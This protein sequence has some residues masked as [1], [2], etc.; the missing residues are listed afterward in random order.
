MC[1]LMLQHNVIPTP[2]LKLSTSLETCNCEFDEQHDC[3]WS[4]QLGRHSTQC[5]AMFASSVYSLAEIYSVNL[6]VITCLNFSNCLLLKYDRIAIMIEYSNKLRLCSVFILSV[7]FIRFQI[8]S[9][10]CV[11][12]WNC[13][14]YI[15]PEQRALLQGGK[16][17]SLTWT[18]WTDQC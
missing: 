1:M 14:S 18:M 12:S 3:Y 9:V 6:H 16:T 2:I 15:L 10:F 17:S 5:H 13:K 4:T 11:Q 7:P 8:M